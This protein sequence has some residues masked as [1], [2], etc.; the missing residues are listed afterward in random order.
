M[1]TGQHIKQ[2]Y[3]EGGRAIEYYM[4]PTLNPGVE[5][6]IAFGGRMLSDVGMKPED[7][8]GDTIESLYK[9]KSAT[10]SDKLVRI[11]QRAENAYFDNWSPRPPSPLSPPGELHLTELFGTTPGSARYLTDDL[12]GGPLMGRE[13][14]AAYK[15]ELASILD[16]VS[17]VEGSVAEGGRVRIDRIKACIVNTLADIEVIEKKG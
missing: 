9:P 3:E 2:L 11:F 5:V 12:R 10:T 15:R 7:V 1:R 16:D 8:L 17:K 6:N 13:G 4:G 14:R